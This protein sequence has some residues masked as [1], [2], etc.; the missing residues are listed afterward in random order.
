MP[1]CPQRKEHYRLNS[2]FS[3]TYGINYPMKS[4]E[5]TKQS[6]CA[7]FNSAHISSNE[8]YNKYIPA[9]FHYFKLEGRTWPSKIM[10]TSLAD[11][12]IKP[13]YKSFFLRAV[14]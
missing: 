3:L 13:E 14:L 1:G 10:A 11:Y 2:L 5:I 4:C 9:G 12:L 7:L 6:M 8:L